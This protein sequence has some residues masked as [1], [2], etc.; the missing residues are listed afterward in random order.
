MVVN[1]KISNRLLYIFML[2]LL[3]I[4]ECVFSQQRDQIWWDDRRFIYWY[5]HYRQ[6]TQFM[7]PA[8]LP[9]DQTDE[10]DW[11]RYLRFQSNPCSEEFRGLSQT[12]NTRD[13]Y[14]YVHPLAP[15][16]TPDNFRWGVTCDGDPLTM[17]GWYLGTL[18]TEYKILANTGQATNNTLR[19]LWWA[20]ATIERLDAEAEALLWPVGNEN[21]NQRAGGFRNPN[22]SLCNLN[23]FIMRSDWY[24][25]RSEDFGWTFPDRQPPVPP[26]DPA[27]LAY[28]DNSV[29]DIF[30]AGTNH[31][32]WAC[33]SIYD[34][35]WGTP[36]PVY[37]S[38]YRGKG[39]YMSQDQL[40]GVM[41]GLTLVNQ[42]V[43]QNVG[44]FQRGDIREVVQRITER[45][46]RRL[47]NADDQSPNFKIP[48]SIYIPNTVG[49]GFNIA[50]YNDNFID[51]PFPPWN[52]IG[53][54]HGGFITVFRYPFSKAAGNITGTH[55]DYGQ[56][57]RVFWDVTRYLP[58]SREANLAGEGVFRSLWN[59][60]G[61]YAF[62]RMI[63]W[64]RA[65]DIQKREM[66]GLITPLAAIT[67]TWEKVISVGG[68]NVLG[69]SI[70]KL[71]LSI[72]VTGER[73]WWYNEW[74]DKDYLKDHVLHDY[75]FDNNQSYQTEL[76]NVI[77]TAPCAGPGKRFTR[78]NTDCS[79]LPGRD[80]DPDCNRYY[81]APEGWRCPNRWE[82]PYDQN[83]LVSGDRRGRFDGM[84]YML[85]Y[86]LFRL[87][88]PGGIETNMLD[89]VDFNENITQGHRF[90]GHPQV[91]FR[92]F[93][94]NDCQA[95]GNANLRF[96]TYGS[97]EIKHDS[98]IGDF[99]EN[100]SAR[101]EAI[102]DDLLANMCDATN[103]LGMQWGPDIEEQQHRRDPPGGPPPGHGPPPPYPP[104]IAAE[105]RQEENLYGQYF[106]ELYCL[107][108]NEM[109]RLMIGDGT[110]GEISALITRAENCLHRRFSQQHRLTPQLN[111]ANR[112]S[113]IAECL[114]PQDHARLSA[115]RMTEDELNAKLDSCGKSGVIVAKYL[116]HLH[117]YP[118]P[119]MDALQ[120]GFYLPLDDQ[121]TVTLYNAQG[122]IL[123]QETANHGAGFQEMRIPTADL[124]PGAYFCRIQLG[125][126]CQV[127]QTVIKAGR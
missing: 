124:P 89:R 127:V 121:V 42:L 123:K 84:D 90:D 99:N 94:L 77:A 56:S 113:L 12:G 2:F 50:E 32:F 80:S 122:Q 119:F 19:E 24:G 104:S 39:D 95:S 125:T 86:N 71:T 44:Y 13:W 109:M 57:V 45:I 17:Q 31:E 3:M 43:P 78:P 15:D 91:G 35:A 38:G 18:A 100:G 52:I 7:E 46:F 83:S 16:G 85:P 33:G 62:I 114:T 69:F 10:A 41:T 5:Y 101:F 75:L 49:D 9:P 61:S 87:K 11:Q 37:G 27:Y 59:F 118:N 76:S 82:W 68:G 105:A 120:V 72:P 97:G 126:Q 40:I 48:W 81:F 21:E 107:N 60:M 115:G 64:G 66:I 4:P 110:Q 34:Q 79:G 47:E 70:P 65:T 93:A 22:R 102:Q 20:L 29:P 92:S 26:S 108:L 73:L 23:G 106:R 74:S 30:N 88:W 55:Y 117:V 96:L 14:N 116:H 63:T 98:R 111:F 53:N 54:K 25:H 6:L 1:M 28:Y 8:G 103:R 67:D 58:I 36:D 51:A 112:D